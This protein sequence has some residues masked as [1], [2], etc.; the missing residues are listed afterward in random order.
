MTTTTKGPIEGYLKV[1]PEVIRDGDTA[2]ID[3]QGVYYKFLNEAVRGALAEGAKKIVI[4]N[5]NGQ[6]YIGTGLKGKDVRIEVH[7]TPGQDM[8]MFMDGPD[9]R[10]LRQRARRCRQHHELGQ[11]RSCMARRATCSATAC[12]AARCSSRAMSA[13]VSAFT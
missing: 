8:A 9:A 2:T 13:I 11:S 1:A 4:N 7:G 10:G 12:A 3:S 5:V 6:R